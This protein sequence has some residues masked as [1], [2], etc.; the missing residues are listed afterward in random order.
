MHDMLYLGGLL[1]MPT[2]FMFMPRLRWELRL[3]L[4][5]LCCHAPVLGLLGK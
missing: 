3:R 2:I 1:G 4:P 5:D